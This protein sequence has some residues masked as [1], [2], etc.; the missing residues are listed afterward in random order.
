LFKASRYIVGLLCVSAG[1]ALAALGIIVIA[2]DW[3]GG[4]WWKGLIALLASPVALMIPLLGSSS[5]G[6]ALGDYVTSAD[7]ADGHHHHAD[8][9]G[10]GYWEPGP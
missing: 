5:G 4:P 7:G 9:G 3:I 10:T 2:T 1:V 8:S 6:D